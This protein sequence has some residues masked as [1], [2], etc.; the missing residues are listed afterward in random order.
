M[1]RSS[2]GPKTRLSLEMSDQ[3]RAMLEN[4]RVKTDAD[5]LAEVIRKALAVYDLVWTAKEKGKTLL[6]KG[7]GD[8]DDER[9]VII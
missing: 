3:A 6:L 9:V 8:G 2:N 5:S 1:A 7:V 4:L